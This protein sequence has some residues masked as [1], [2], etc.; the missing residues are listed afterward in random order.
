ME[1]ILEFGRIMTARKEGNQWRQQD[2]NPPQARGATCRMLFIEGGERAGY[3]ACEDATVSTLLIAFMPL[4]MVMYM[5]KYINSLIVANVIIDLCGTVVDI[6][7]SSCIDLPRLLLRLQQ[8]CSGAA[9]K[10]NCRHRRL[11]FPETGNAATSALS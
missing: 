6:V 3:G 11:L 4:Q 5:L 8:P 9:S 7:F 2:R 1:T 10:S